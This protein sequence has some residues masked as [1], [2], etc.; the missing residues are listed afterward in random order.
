MKEH[1]ILRRKRIF[2]KLHHEE[3][4]KGR[5][6]PRLCKYRSKGSLGRDKKGKLG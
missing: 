2:K 4:G 6:N 3:R 5:M 1:N